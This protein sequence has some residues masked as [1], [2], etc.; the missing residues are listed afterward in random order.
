MLEHYALTFSKLYLRCGYTDLQ[1]SVDSLAALINKEY[2]LDPFDCNSIFLFCGRR[3]DRIKLLTWNGD[4]WLL[5]YK[6]LEHSKYQWPRST[7]EVAELTHQ[8]LR[9]LLEGLSIT[10]NRMIRKVSPK[11]VT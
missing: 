2:Q 1:Y 4:G 3:A 6:R 9:W 10:P 5:M 8:Q 11:R 7:T